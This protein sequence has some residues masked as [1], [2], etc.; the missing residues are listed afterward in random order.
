MTAYNDLALTS[1]KTFQNHMEIKKL[2][3]DNRKFGDKENN[4]FAITEMCVE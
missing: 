4:K 3:R 2:K 1:T